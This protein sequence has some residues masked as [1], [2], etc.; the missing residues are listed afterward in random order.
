MIGLDTNILVRFL[1]GDDAKQAQQVYPLFKKNEQEKSLMFV[2]ALVV[3]E[4]ILA[5]DSVYGIS[6]SDILESLDELMRMPVLKFENQAA[7]A[8]FVRSA[9]DNAHDLPD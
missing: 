2:P 1:V 7:L 4:L 9:Q 5:L 6:R 3:L 8:Q